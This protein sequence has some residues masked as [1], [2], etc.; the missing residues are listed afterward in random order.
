MSVQHFIFNMTPV[1][2]WTL[3]SLFMAIRYFFVAGTVFWIFYKLFKSKFARRKI[4]KKIPKWSQLKKEIRSSIQTILIFGFIALL[5][6]FLRMN[7]M[8]AM[9][10]D[11]QTF[12]VFYFAG[13]I[14][15]ILV[16]H[17]TYFYWLHYT[18][19]HS[20]WL[21]K[22]HAHH[23]KSVNPTPFTAMSFHPV[24]SILEIGFFAVVILILPV[25]PIALAIAGTWSLIFNILGHSGYELFPSGFLDRPILKWLNT[26]THHN[27]HHRLG[28][29]NYGLYFNFWDTI[30]NTNFKNYKRDFEQVASN[31]KTL[32]E[33]I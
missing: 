30:M 22:F 19:H 33:T 27:M 16:L 11:I 21:M 7:G 15:L 2:F 14:V 25:H 9:Y 3:S 5:I 12:S 24:E 26:P 4:Q 10:D 28:N 32:T 8:T 23:H 13:S 20:P 17:D 29:G 6:R 31:Q 18:F 1:E